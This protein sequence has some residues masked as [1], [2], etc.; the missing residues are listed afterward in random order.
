MSKIALSAPVAGVG[1]ATIKGPETA[2]DIEFQLP[3]RAGQVLVVPPAF[4]AYRSTNVSVTPSTPTT[5]L[6]DV[7]TLDTNSWYDPATGRFTP[8]VAGLYL[9]YCTLRGYSAGAALGFA[10]AAIQKNG[11]SLQESVGAPYIT[12]YGSAAGSVLVSMN[13]TTDYVSVSASV[14]G[15]TTSVLGGPALTSFGGHLVRPA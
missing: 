1:T 15:T 4:H 10:A 8:Q 5:V 3:P 2:A 14:A 7:E 12:N 11:I 13:G 9:V 6:F